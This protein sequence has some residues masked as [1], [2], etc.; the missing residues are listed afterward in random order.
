MDHSIAVSGKF[1]ERYLLDELDAADL[2]DFEE[3][4][5]ECPLCAGDIRGATRMVA[6]LKAV[7]SEDLGVQT[8][9]IDGAAKFLDLAIRMK[10][11]HLSALDCVFQFAHS[12]IPLVVRGT[13]LAGVLRLQVP[14]D[15]LPA[16]ACTVLVCAKDSRDALERHQFV[17][18]RG[19]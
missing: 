1:T 17:L 4:F 13:P 12:A 7:L 15:G 8:I 18:A 10:T 2:A 3:H 16:G 5:F 14:V 11:S 19:V 6:S 9:D